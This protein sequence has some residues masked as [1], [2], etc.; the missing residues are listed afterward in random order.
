M[1]LRNSLIREMTHKATCQSCKHFSTFESRRNI[2]SRDLPPVLAVN[3]S[4]YNEEN[5]KIWCDRSP[6]QTFLQPTVEIRGQVG[7]VD[8]MEIV[9]YEL[10]VS[11]YGTL[12]VIIRFVL[13]PLKSIVVQVTPRER[14][15]SP[16]LVSIVKG[17]HGYTTDNSYR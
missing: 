9:Q 15:A 13:I 12:F 10:R 14:A 7:G 5:I 11:I 17:E 6:K 1:V 16:H 2:P 3:A 8:D 4:A